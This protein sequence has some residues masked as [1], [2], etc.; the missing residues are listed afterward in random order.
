MS[1]AKQ[2][3]NP[4]PRQA[5]QQQQEAQRKS[6]R[7]HRHNVDSAD[8]SSASAE[9]IQRAIIATS[10]I[11]VAMQFGLTQDGGALVIRFVGDGDTPYNEFIRPS[12]D[13]DLHLTGVCE[14]FEN[15]R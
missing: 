15:D 12:E 8:W 9:L 10:R 2:D 5:K 1:R 13:V 11:G 14:D 4:N 7:E 3:K 6:R